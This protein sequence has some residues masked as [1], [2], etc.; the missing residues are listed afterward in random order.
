MLFQNEKRF[1]TGKLKRPAGYDLSVRWLLEAYLNMPMNSENLVIVP[2]MTSY[3]RI[4][5]RENITEEMIKNKNVNSSWVGLTVKGFTTNR[6][7]LGS[8]FVK[9]LAPIKVKDYLN[10]NGFAQFDGRMLSNASF[11]LT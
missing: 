8:V 7:R 5:E 10:A 9:Y 11:K 3:D 1:R 2:V 6:D 4:F